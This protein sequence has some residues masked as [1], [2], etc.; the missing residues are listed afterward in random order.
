MTNLPSD[1]CSI[2]FGV[3][4]TWFC[5]PLHPVTHQQLLKMCFPTTVSLQSLKKN[6]DLGDLGRPT[7]SF[8]LIKPNG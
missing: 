8:L 1:L 2:Y 3:P 6:I 5:S 7:K 4:R